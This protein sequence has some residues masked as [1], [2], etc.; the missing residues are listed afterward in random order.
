MPEGGTAGEVAS[1]RSAPPATV[2]MPAAVWPGQTA[3]ARTPR[4]A[5]STASIC[6]IHSSALLDTE[7]APSPASGQS[8]APRDDCNDRSAAVAEGGQAGASEE[9]RGDDVRLDHRIPGGV[10]RLRQRCPVEHSGGEHQPVE[11]TQHRQCLIDDLSRSAW[12]RDIAGNEPCSGPM[13][14]FL[15][16]G[17]VPA[18]EH[19]LGAGGS[20]PLEDGAPDGAGAPGDEDL[21]GRP[22][23]SLLSV[24]H[25]RE[26]PDRAVTGEFGILCPPLLP[27]VEGS[28]GVDVLRLPREAHVGMLSRTA[29]HPFPA[30]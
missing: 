21:D 24:G 7:Y 14:Q 6:V 9:E 29:H 1:T 25:R 10:A 23:R 20:Q 2:P 12:F 15:G 22:P 4:V 19:H 26:H 8:A 11:A 16:S 13:G 18:R 5:P 3:L 28:P 30:S 17:P 27:R